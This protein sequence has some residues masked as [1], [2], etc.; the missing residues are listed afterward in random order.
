M[1]IDFITGVGCYSRGTTSSQMGKSMAVTLP[2]LDETRVLG[3]FVSFM[4]CSGLL[5]YFLRGRLHRLIAVG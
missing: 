2:R 1:T 3:V 4:F 5:R